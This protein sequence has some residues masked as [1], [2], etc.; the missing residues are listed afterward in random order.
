MDAIFKQSNNNNVL[1]LCNNKQKI[2][3]WQ[4]HIDCLLDHI[5]VRKPNESTQS[6]NVDALNVITIASVEYAVNNIYEFTQLQYE[7]VILQDQALDIS[8]E[9][10]EQLK[11]IDVKRKIILCSDDL[12]VCYSSH[13]NIFFFF[14]KQL[15]FACDFFLLLLSIE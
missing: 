14:A 11:Q 9:S 5:T 3:Y 6:E 13:F 2:N 15:Q 8:T 4:F 1:V 12:I 7:C 10:F